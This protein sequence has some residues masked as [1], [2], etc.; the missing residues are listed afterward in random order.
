[1]TATR[2]NYKP[3]SSYSVN[4]A[5]LVGMAYDTTHAVFLVPIPYG[6][7]VSSATLDS[8]TVS[9]VDMITG[10][11]TT[12]LAVQSV[13]IYRAEATYVVI[14]VRI[15]TASLTSNHVVRFSGSTPTVTL[16]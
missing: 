15:T 5:M 3:P 14:N 10:S 8:S 13:G 9:L 6:M 2:L 11:N 4:L 12:G 1:M 7:S 16:S